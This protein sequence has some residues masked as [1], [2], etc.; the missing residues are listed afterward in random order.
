MRGQSTKMKATVPFV[1]ERLIKRGPS[2]L[3]VYECFYHSKSDLI[4]TDGSNLYHSS[5]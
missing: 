5:R 2:M 3:G 4:Q 1:R